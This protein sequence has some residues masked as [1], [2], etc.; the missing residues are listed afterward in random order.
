[1]DRILA[2]VYCETRGQVGLHFKH[3][4]LIFSVRLEIIHNLEFRDN[5]K[6][7]APEMVQLEDTS[8]VA[9]HICDLLLIATST[10]LVLGTTQHTKQLVGL[11]T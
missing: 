6:A 10:T 11:P 3:P 2:C 5:N 1:M 7:N 4:T 8:H 9:S